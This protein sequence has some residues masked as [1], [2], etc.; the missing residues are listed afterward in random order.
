MSDQVEVFVL[1]HASKRG[2]TSELLRKQGISHYVFVN[3]DWEMPADHAE[4]LTDRSYRPAQRD[5]AIRQYRAMRGHQE[6]CRL[7]RAPVTLVFEDDAT[8]M[9]QEFVYAAAR[10]ATAMLS[11]GGDYDAVSFHG[12]NLSPHTVVQTFGRRRYAALQPRLITEKAQ[13]EFLKPLW[14]T[15]TTVPL[16]LALKWHE[17]CLM[18]AISRRGRVT[19]SS[20]DMRAGWPCDLFLVNQLETLVLLDSPV[21]HGGKSLMVEPLG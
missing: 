14:E 21:V 16:P 8:A 17:G 1:A 2:T 4:L 6:I 5:Y 11:S 9:P 12:R 19:W 10:D 7:A 13:Q 3:P 18:Y 20:A 15:T